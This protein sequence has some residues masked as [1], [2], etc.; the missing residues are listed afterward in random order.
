[1]SENKS[2]KHVKYVG[3]E[4]AQAHRYSW[5]GPRSYT[6]RPVSTLFAV[7]FLKKIIIIF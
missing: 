5:A 1:M 2:M 6:T 3:I 4:L 7:F